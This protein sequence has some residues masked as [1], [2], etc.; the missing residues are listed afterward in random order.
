M[1]TSLGMCWYPFR[2]KEVK[3]IYENLTT[4]EASRLKQHSWKVG[5]VFGV[6]IPILFFPIF[7][8]S[9]PYFPEQGRLWWTLIFAIPLGLIVGLIGGAPIRS[10]AKKL[11]CESAYAKQKGYTADNLRLYSF[12]L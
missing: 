10:K 9:M 2:S 4:D 1:K 3:A 5:G 8:F 11:L 6:L 12:G 7:L